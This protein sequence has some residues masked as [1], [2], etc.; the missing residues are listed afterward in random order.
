MLVRVTEDRFGSVIMY[1]ACTAGERKCHAALKA[2]NLRAELSAFG[3]GDAGDDL[4]SLIPKAKAR[5]VR[6]GYNVVVR[7]DDSVFFQLLGV[8]V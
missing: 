6:D 4:L 3:Q 1:P 8:E 2:A 7:M 5:D